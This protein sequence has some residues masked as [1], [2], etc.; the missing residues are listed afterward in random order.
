MKRRTR[1]RNLSQRAALATVMVVSLATLTFAKRKDDI[2]VTKNGDR[3]T[4]EIK[5]L[6]Q[7]LLSF[8]S[9]YMVSSVQLN[10]A[11]V[12]RLQSED[13]YVVTFTSGMRMAGKLQRGRDKQ[14]GQPSFA[15]GV[16]E[17]RLAVEPNQVIAIEQA[18]GSF[19]KHVKGNADAGLSYTSGTNPTSGYL[20]AAAAYVT[21]KNEVSAS[22]STQFSSQNNAPNSFRY[23]LDTQ[24]LRIF[25]RRWYGIGQFDLLKSDQQDLNL[26]T[27]YGGGAGRRLVQTDRSAFMVYGG[28]VYTH[29]SY[30]ASA[31]PGS[32]Q[33]DAEGLLGAQYTTFRFKTLDISWTGA[34]YPGI[35][36]SGRVRFTTTGNLKIELIKDLYWSFQLYENYDTRPPVNASKNDFGVTTSLG[37][38][39]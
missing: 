2:V 11:E 23:T 12:D 30:F 7:G 22:T 28:L 14:T 33:S 10:W 5:G 6:N 21:D 3:L 37:W 29:A 4:G 39:F 13:A 31:G 1:A 8:K 32:N 24:Y 25:Q 17:D 16:A 15:V 35:T 20:S 38:K 26:R 34:M 18:E 9:S 19:L 27:T 36:D